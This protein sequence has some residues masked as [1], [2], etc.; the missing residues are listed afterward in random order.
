LIQINAVL[1]NL[2]NILFMEKAI[3]SSIWNPIAA[4]PDGVELELCVYE[5]GEYHALAFPCRR[6]GVGWSDVRLKRMV[7]IRPTHW[8][9]WPRERTL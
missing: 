9:L 6:N 1:R 5:R 2:R 3:S 8:R 4:A 7:P